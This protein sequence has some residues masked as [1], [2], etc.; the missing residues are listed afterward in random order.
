VLFRIFQYFVVIGSDGGGEIVTTISEREYP[1]KRGFLFSLQFPLR[2]AVFY[3]AYVLELM[4]INLFKRYCSVVLVMELF[5]PSRQ[6]T[7]KR[8]R[9][10]VV[11]LL[12][13][14]KFFCEKRYVRSVFFV[15]N[16]YVNC[17]GYHGVSN[18][19]VK[20]LRGKKRTCTVTVIS[21]IYCNRKNIL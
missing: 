5:V 19:S 3:L 2:G 7:S 4:F 21:P 11:C 14:K 18:C 6:T 16:R 1:L 10:N 15:T 20:N 17:R 9:N 13:Y 12:A 8:R